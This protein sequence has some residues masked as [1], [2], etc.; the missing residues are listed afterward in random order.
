M[1][2]QF[3]SP[4]N[5]FFV[6]KTLQTYHTL[7]E[8]FK[9]AVLLFRVGDQYETI[10]DDATVLS[11]V[12]G[13]TPQNSTDNNG[14]EQRACIPG[15]SLAVALRKLVKSGYKVA[16][17]EELESPKAGKNSLKRHTKDRLQQDEILKN[18]AATGG[19]FVSKDDTRKRWFWYSLI[20]AQSS[21]SRSAG[22][23]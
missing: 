5:L 18:L 3:A 8:K 19:V 22:L 10:D 1:G 21:V 13:V 16:R 11:E 9:E 14:G 6:R 15:H 17:C 12:M 23:Q 4:Q 20:A 7:K 2:R